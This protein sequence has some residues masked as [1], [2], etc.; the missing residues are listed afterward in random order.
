PRGIGSVHPPL[1]AQILQNVSHHLGIESHFFGQQPARSPG[2]A[3]ATPP[4]VSP[5]TASPSHVMPTAIVCP[6][7]CSIICSPEFRAARSINYPPDYLPAN[8]HHFRPT[9]PSLIP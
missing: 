1:T 2:P 6:L 5:T 3:R 9:I 7:T 8:H 4:A